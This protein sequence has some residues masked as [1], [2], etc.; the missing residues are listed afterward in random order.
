MRIGV[1]LG[2]V[3]A[4]AP[5]P[6]AAGSEDFAARGLY[7]GA[8]GSSTRNEIAEDEIED[9][10][11]GVD[12]DV[13]D[14]WAAR[15]VLGY[16]F[17]PWLAAEVE[18]EHMGGFE[19]G[20]LGVD[21][22]TARA[23]VLTANLKAIVPL[24]RTQPYLLL[25]IGGA[26]WHFD[27]EAGVGLSGGD[28]SLAARVGAGVDF[29]LTRRLSLDVG[30]DIVLSDPELG[31]GIPGVEDVDFLGYATAGAALQYRFTGP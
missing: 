11:P 26:R 17:L 28:T 4:V 12:V 9:V 1:A 10:L 21:I 16:R 24:W 30:A 22:A 8:G 13:D 20:G 2:V 15:G 6:A 27:D 7:A 19:L 14:S 5:L 29:H 23:D 31:T 25:G 3:L 18:Y